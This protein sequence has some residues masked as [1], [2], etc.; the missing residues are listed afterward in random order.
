MPQDINLMPQEVLKTRRTARGT[1]AFTVVSIGIFIFCMLGAVA[2]FGYETFLLRT[3]SNFQN[4]SQREITEIQSLEPVERAALILEQKSDILTKVFRERSFYSKLLERLSLEVPQDVVI[5][6]LAVVNPTQVG[7]S[8]EAQSY[9][10]LSKFLRAL[11]SSEE[12]IFD[13]AVLSSVSLDSQ[14]GKAKFA[15]SVYLVEGALSERND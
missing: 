12:D 9:V 4:L 8:G 10:A 11:T 14:S 5:T 15:L 1:R 2:A 7:V 6:D 3:I 13:S